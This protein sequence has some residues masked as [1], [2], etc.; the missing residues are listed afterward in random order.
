MRPTANY[1][2]RWHA[3]SVECSQLPPCLACVLSLELALSLELRFH[4]MTEICLMSPNNLE[5]NSPDLP[6]FEPIIAKASKHFR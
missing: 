6:V 2:S 5:I 1:M 3:S 4:S